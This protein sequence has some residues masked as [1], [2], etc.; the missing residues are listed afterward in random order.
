M[1]VNGLNR[2]ILGATVILQ[3]FVFVI[4]VDLTSASFEDQPYRQQP[5]F[6]AK[7]NNA[8]PKKYKCILVDDDDESSIG[9]I[10]GGVSYVNE[11]Q[12]RRLQAASFVDK[13]QQEQQHRIA[14][15]TLTRP[16]PSRVL[17]TTNQQPRTNNFALPLAE[18]VSVSTLNKNKPLKQITLTR[19]SQSNSI[20][21]ADNSNYQPPAVPIV[22]STAVPPTMKL[23]QEYCN[24]IKHYAALYQ[25]SDVIGWV[26]KNCACKFLT[27]TYKFKMLVLFAK[28]YLPNA[29]CS[30]IN[31]LVASCYRFFKQ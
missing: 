24:M 23:S 28:T 20:F 15:P 29:T 21:N 17:S 1:K 14:T 9:G 25:V 3:L 16:Q 12:Q 8:K 26:S 30:E 22:S 27:R 31:S 4:A 5:R 19:P 11:L 18:E 13:Q 2:L 7:P 6:A 10:A